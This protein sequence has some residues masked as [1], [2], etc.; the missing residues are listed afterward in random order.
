MTI[1]LKT[2]KSTILHSDHCTFILSHDQLKKKEMGGARGTYGEE[3]R[4]TQGF[5]EEA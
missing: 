4:I 5:G 2:D 3:D 1:L